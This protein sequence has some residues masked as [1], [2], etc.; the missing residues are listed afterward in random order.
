VS[1][2][3]GAVDHAARAIVNAPRCGTRMV[4]RRTG[5]WVSAGF[6]AGL[7]VAPRV[8]RWLAAVLVALF[9]A[10]ALQMAYKRAE[11]AL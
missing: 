8:T 2:P 1:S 5:L 11:D 6:V 4:L 7:L 9:G 3:A 10:D